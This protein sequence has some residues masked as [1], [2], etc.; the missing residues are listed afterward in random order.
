M[1]LRI[2]RNPRILCYRPVSSDSS[3]DG[4]KVKE[5]SKADA[6]TSPNKELKLGKDEEVKKTAQPSYLG[7]LS[8]VISYVWPLGSVISGVTIGKEDKSTE[9][10][11]PVAVKRASR[12]EVTQKTDILVKKFLLAESTQSRILRVEE[13]N[14]HLMSYPASRLAAIEKTKLIPSLLKFRAHASDEYLKEESR[15]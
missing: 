11:V 8:G 4:N 9:R 1:L 7:Y 15:Q 2:S 14:R 12:E 13:L 3:K 6:K 10:V 5:V